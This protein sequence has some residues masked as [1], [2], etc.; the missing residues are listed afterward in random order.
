MRRRPPDRGDDALLLSV[1]GCRGGRRGACPGHDV[2][3]GRHRHGHLGGRLPG[4]TVTL[5][6]DA[7]GVSFDDGQQRERRLHV[8]GGA[9]GPVHRGD[10]TAGLQ[11]VRLGGRHG[12]DRRADDDQCRAGARRRSRKPWRSARRAKSCRRERRGTSDRRSTSARSRACRSWADAAATRWTS[13]SHSQGSS[14]AR[15]LAAASTSTARAIDP[16]TS[17]WTGSTRTNRVRAAPTSLRSGRT[18]TH[19]G[20]QGPDGKPD[21]GVRPQQRRTGRHGHAERHQQL[22]RNGV[23]LRSAAGE[24]RQRM[25]EQHRR[26]GEASVHRNTCRASASAARSVGTRRSSS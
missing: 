11:A 3:R 15:T 18:L 20:V 25:G 14:R 21:R 1:I 7:T 5:T 12:H 23:L 19:L 4:A 6:N 26:P 13:C 22:E 24:Q 8:R 10:R 17:R 9:G 2:A 16:G